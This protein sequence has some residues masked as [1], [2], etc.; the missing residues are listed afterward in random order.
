LIAELSTWLLD[1]IDATGYLGLFAAMF[2]EGIVTPIP[3]EMIVPFAGF[4]VRSGDM[5]FALVLLAATIGSTA[6]STVS[7]GLARYL[8]RPFFQRYGK[9]I[10]IDD[11]MMDKAECFFAKHGRSAVLLGHM[12]IGVRSIVSYPAGITKMDLRVFIVFTFSGSLVWNTV[13][14]AA[15]YLLASKWN[16]FWE[17]TDGLDIVIFG[18]LAACASGYLVWMWKRKRC[19][20]D[21]DLTNEKDYS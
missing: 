18:A 20:K 2:L 17:A 5:N 16:D 1:L 19:L 21:N 13:L 7:Y 14:M 4:L 6:G 15:G 11:R 10:F 8:G 3:S 9:W 12:V